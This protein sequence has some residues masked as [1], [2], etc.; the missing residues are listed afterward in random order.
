MADR[1]K[2]SLSTKVFRMFLLGTVVLGLILA[3][4]GLALYSIAVGGQYISTSFN[5]SRSASMVLQ[6]VE[7]P[8]PLC[9]EVMDRY[10][11]M[12]K[13][14]RAGVETEE[15]EARFADI[16]EREDYKKIRTTLGHFLESSDVYDIYL[17]MYDEENNA[18][19]YIADPSE[20]DV[21]LL[22]SAIRGAFEAGLC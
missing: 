16:A 11:S 9:G 20:E 12:T 10:M 22:C 15:Y 5:L 7:D 4:I 6:E 19:V 1:K 13:D 14:E 2:R 18:L 17:A 8:E 3:L 21:A